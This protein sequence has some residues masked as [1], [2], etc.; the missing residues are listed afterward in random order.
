MAFIGYSFGFVAPGATVGVYLHGFPVNQFAGIDVRPTAAP[1]RP[2]AFFPS[3]DI[4]AHTVSQHVDGTLAHTVFV[5]NKSTSN[6]A[7]PTPVVDV[8]VFFDPI[9]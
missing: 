2:T 5:T 9:Q 4:D 3:I 7:P 8:A 1:S 6:G